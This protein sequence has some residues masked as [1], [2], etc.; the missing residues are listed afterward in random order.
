MN[1]INPEQA[2]EQQLDQF[3][4]ECHMK[5]ERALRSGALTDTMLNNGELLAKVIMDSACRDRPFRIRGPQASAAENV[6]LC[7]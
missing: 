6:H 7:V 4:L 3:R 5:L 1:T 2:L